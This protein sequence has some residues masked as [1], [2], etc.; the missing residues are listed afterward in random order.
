MWDS[1]LL[2]WRSLSW[3]G[4]YSLGQKYTQNLPPRHVAKDE[5]DH[6]RKA[7]LAP[8]SQ[9]TKL[10]LDSWLFF[11][12][13]SDSHHPGKWSHSGAWAV[14]NKF[15]TKGDLCC[16]VLLFQ[17]K[18][19]D[20]WRRSVTMIGVHSSVIL[21]PCVWRAVWSYFSPRLL[22]IR[23]Y[24]FR[25]QP[26]SVL[27]LTKEP[28]NALSLLQPFVGNWV[29]D[30]PDITR[31]QKPSKAGRWGSVLSIPRKEK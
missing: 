30:V 6:G 3:K 13:C 11:P 23:T 29:G 24:W 28:R 12:G 8:W 27:S 16:V 20:S 10:T 25:L 26:S 18:C 22:N 17:H 2:Q 1:F 5:G 4:R 14:S 21:M 19:H 15:C 7:N 9:D 31:Y